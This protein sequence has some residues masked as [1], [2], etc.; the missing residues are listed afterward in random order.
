[1]TTFKTKPVYFY[2]FFALAFIVLLFWQPDAGY[3][4]YFWISWARDIST[5]GLGNIYLNPE[6]NYHPFVLYLL[7]IYTWIYA[8]ANIP[9][10][11]INGF[12]SIIVVF[13]L[14]T[15][16]FLVWLLN[17]WKI[18]PLW[19]LLLILNPAF[20]YNTLI[21]GQT[22]TVYTFFIFVALAALLNRDN[23]TA[24][25]MLLLALNTK[26]Q[27]VI[28]I[29]IFI[30]LAV[31]RKEK[32]DWL[33]II[34]GLIALQFVLLSPFIFS[35]NLW[36][37]L[38]A[39]VTGSVDQFPVLSRNAFNLWYLINSDPFTTSDMMKL[40]GIPAKYLGLFAF[41]L[42]YLGI[43]WL[44]HLKLKTT[45]RNK[46]KFAL[47]SLVFVLVVLCFFWF[48]TQ[49]HERYVH[50]AILFSGIAA[51]LS[52]YWVL[53]GIISVAYLL[54]LEAVM[55]YLPYILPLKAENYANLP[56]FQPVIISMLFLSAIA[57]ALFHL[58][59]FKPSEN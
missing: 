16:A 54:N 5:D 55:Q 51:I 52:R 37:S 56:V 19:I 46:D 7:K 28:F 25:L 23:L 44:L 59:K 58:V 20:W 22:D 49:M 6:V 57:L 33:R 21:W 9:E 34:Y 8:N 13:D 39:M 41:S 31:S 48:N 38:Q 10:E 43:G 29:P 1:M 50:A 45:F 11:A 15:L 40:M 12:K 35:G 53:L 24:S 42:V 32:V 27:A 17:R 36:V 2:A 18:N 3:D 4:K 26:L 30:Y 14:G 47:I